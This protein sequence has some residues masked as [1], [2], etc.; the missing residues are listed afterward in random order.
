MITR[1]APLAILALVLPGWAETD[2]QILRI[3]D[4]TAAEQA[5]VSQADQVA[6]REMDIG[7]ALIGQRNYTGALNRFKIVVTR[8]QASRH[9]EEAWERIVEAYLALGIVCEAQNVASVLD[10]KFPDGR[11]TAAAREALK[12]AG[13]EP[14]ENERRCY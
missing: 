14:A 11:W 12:A 7:R 6:G 9:V 3:A 1:V 13:L 10:Q 5:T 2:D 8:Y 4:N